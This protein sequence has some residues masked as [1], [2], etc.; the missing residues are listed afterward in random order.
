MN[1]P[2]H[3]SHL[4]QGIS[5]ASTTSAETPDAVLD[6]MEDAVCNTEPQCRYLVHGG[7][8]P[9]DWYCVRA[10]VSLG[11][12]CNKGGIC[13]LSGL[14]CG[15]SIFKANTEHTVNGVI[16]FCLNI[17][18]CKM[19]T[20]KTCSKLGE[21][22]LILWFM[23]LKI[24]PNHCYFAPVNHRLQPGWQRPLLAERMRW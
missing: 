3:T 17:L 16:L 5:E 7:K 20:S 19:L 15:V 2:F 13:T 14:V 18:I 9:L 22:G 1:F 12:F 11:A 21:N 24:D 4:L 10:L 8:K 23:V 6:A